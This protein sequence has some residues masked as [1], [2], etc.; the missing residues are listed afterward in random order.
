MR[1]QKDVQSAL[2]KATNALATN[3]PSTVFS[4]MNLLLSNARH[5]KLR[6]RQSLLAMSGSESRRLSDLSSELE[7]R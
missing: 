4:K 6:P 5:R 3:S 2:T 7:M 1:G